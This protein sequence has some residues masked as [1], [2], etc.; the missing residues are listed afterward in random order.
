MIYLSEMKQIVITILG[1]TNPSNQSPSSLPG[2]AV[3]P[4]VLK[5]CSYCSSLG[6][7]LSQG[8]LLHPPPLFFSC[9]DLLLLHCCT[10]GCLGAFFS[11]KPPPQYAPA[12]SAPYIPKGG[13]FVLIAPVCCSACFTGTDM[14]QNLNTKI[15]CIYLFSRNMWH[16]NEYIYRHGH[17]YDHAL[18]CLLWL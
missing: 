11:D 18:M 12:G 9:T 7:I 3:A 2:A 1:D 8:P 13:I 5:L 14:T 10:I 6:L 17:K 4:H 15:C 16:L